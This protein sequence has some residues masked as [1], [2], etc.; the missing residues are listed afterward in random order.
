MRQVVALTLAVALSGAA[1]A[2]AQNFQPSCT[3]TLRFSYAAFSEL[4]VIRNADASEAGQD[5]AAQ[6]WADCK[7]QENLRRLGSYPQLKARLEALRKAYL[8]LLNADSSITSAR[9]GGGTMYT[10]DLVRAMPDLELHLADLISY[11]TSPL[12]ASSGQHA[13]DMYRLA[14]RTLD[15][16]LARLKKPTQNDLDY[17]DRSTWN[18]R[19]KEYEQAVQAIRAI[20][21]K[22]ADVT[23]SAILSFAAQG[24][25]LSNPNLWE[26]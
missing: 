4:Y 5:D 22:K 20:A 17:V 3:E 23:S 15:Q 13:Q 16:R 7:R 8:S 1:P 18:Q 21:G 25:F 19:V 9:M 2:L 10:H 24:L 14:S 6:Y 11:T 26:D 12:G